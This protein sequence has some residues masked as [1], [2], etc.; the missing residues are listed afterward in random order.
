MKTTYRKIKNLS[1]SLSILIM[2][3]LISTSAIGQMCD[4]T[5]NNNGSTGGD[6]EYFLEVDATG[7]ITSVTLGPGPLNV[8][9]LATGSVVTI[10][11]LVYDS[12]NPPTNVPPAIGDDPT[13]I[14]G[15]TN[16]FL[17]AP[18]F[19]ECLC[20]DD[21]ISASYAPGGGDVLIYYLTDGNGVILDSNAT[22]NFGTDE[23]I[24]DYFI[25]VLAYDS[26][27]PPTVIPT[28]GDN[29]SV[30]SEDGCYNPD[31][32]TSACCAQKI[33]CCPASVTTPIDVMLDFCDISPVVT[34]DE[35]GIVLDNG[36]TGAVYTW[37]TGD[38]L[39]A[40]G[41][42]TT[43][44]VSAFGTEP[45]LVT[46]Q[47]FYLNVDC[48]TPLPV[49]L[50]GGTVTINV[51]PGP[52]ADIADLVTISGENGCDEPILTAIAGCEG[53]IDIVEEASNPIFPVNIGDSGSAEYN[54]TYVPNTAGPDCC[55]VT[56]DVIVSANYNCVAVCPTSVVTP[57]DVSFDFCSE[58]GAINLDEAG[59]V[60]DASTDAT[61]V[62]STG[63]YLSNGG[64][65]V[66][67]PVSSITTMDCNITTQ[68]FY[69]N[70]DCS[71]TPLAV[72]LDGG[73]YTVNIYPGPPADLSDLVTITG[74]NTCNEPMITAIPG[75][76]S[77]ITVTPNPG[78]TSF[79]VDNGDSGQAFYIIDFTSD[80]AGPSCCAGD[81]EQIINASYNCDTGCNPSSGT[82]SI[83]A[84]SGGN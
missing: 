10:Y 66:S 21:E 46:T 24:G 80:P 7:I 32:L 70:V 51:Y 75:C 3:T 68:I 36:G 45:C 29:I 42:A 72:T 41:T 49:T 25:Q 33:N 57:L 30:F 5:I 76:E 55:P 20:V 39:S 40:G 52:P 38:Y 47:V 64:T 8:N 23:V 58:S 53:Y 82:I 17:G 63:G 13:N 6:T 61:F 16:D 15:C 74:E 28:V 4:F 22:G 54:I 67:S 69:L 84:V 1:R 27:N 2:L 62:W 14:V 44:S 60:L 26:T 19:L 73:T 81:C 77:F 65:V 78:N 79:P 18:I 83:K 56:C 37:S 12:A 43:N 50:D 11:N 9:G 35:T 59:V 31:F 34:L 71:S 48:D